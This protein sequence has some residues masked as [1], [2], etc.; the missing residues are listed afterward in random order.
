MSP[1][2]APSVA[3]LG[4]DDAKSNLVGP[5]G[6]VVVWA[7]TTVGGMSPVGEEDELTAL[8]DPQQVQAR[9]RIGIVLHGKW[10]LDALL[11]IGGMAAVYSATHR[12]GSRADYKRRRTLDAEHT[13]R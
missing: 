11:G 10:K 6:A 2:V 9:A 8:E 7:V 13:L 3:A 4:R 12:N 5:A 1:D